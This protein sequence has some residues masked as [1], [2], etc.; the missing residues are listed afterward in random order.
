LSVLFKV[1]CRLAD[2]LKSLSQLW[3]SADLMLMEVEGGN[4]LI[5]LSDF[6]SK[7]V[8]NEDVIV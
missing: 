4:F 6:C 5:A 8:V 7:H 3:Q 2:F 1:G